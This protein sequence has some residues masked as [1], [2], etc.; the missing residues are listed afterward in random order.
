MLKG[1]Q[2]QKLIICMKFKNIYSKTVL[3]W[4]ESIEEKSRFYIITLMQKKKK[5]IIQTSQIV[6]YIQQLAK[7]S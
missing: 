2:I 1:L 6:N 7:K 5:K 4:Y 3:C